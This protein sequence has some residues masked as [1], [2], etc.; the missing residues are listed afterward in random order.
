MSNIRDFSSS[1]Y[2]QD[3]R[4]PSHTL[5]ERER[6]L[7]Y[8]RRLSTRIAREDPSIRANPLIRESKRSNFV[9]RTSVALRSFYIYRT[10]EREYESDITSRERGEVSRHQ[11]RTDTHINSISMSDV[12]ES[13]RD[14]SQRSNLG[15]GVSECIHTCN[16]IKQGIS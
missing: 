3:A 13:E 6:A 1:E 16:P 9:I 8:A 5:R 10:R 14:L 7:C 11:T 12:C 2:I 15:Y 4:G